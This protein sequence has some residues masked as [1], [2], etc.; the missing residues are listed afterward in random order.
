MRTKAESVTAVVIYDG[1]RSY[2]RDANVT[3]FKV[4]AGVATIGEYAYYD[5]PELES[6]GV[7]RE[8][9]KAI[10]DGAFRGC[11]RLES[12]QGL[13]RSLTTIGRYAFNSTGLTSLDGLPSALT[14]VGHYAFADCALLTSIG[15]GFPPDCDVHPDAFYNCPAL[16]VAAQSR[17]FSSAALWGK[18]RWYVVNCRFAALLAVLQVC[19]ALPHAPASLLERLAFL[20]NDLVREVVEFVGACE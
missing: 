9:V 13:P 19:R 5:C 16:V 15:P 6:L 18:N 7:M 12:L 1:S 17:G 14:A 10:R 2:I 11:S 4:A 8:G 3:S 20:P